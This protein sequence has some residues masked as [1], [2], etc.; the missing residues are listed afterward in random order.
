MPP[1]LRAALTTEAKFQV[2]QTGLSLV[3][4]RDKIESVI[5]TVVEKVKSLTVQALT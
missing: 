4:E 5:D 1:E 3:V 2:T